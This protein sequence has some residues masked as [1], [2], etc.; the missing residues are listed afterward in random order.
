MKINDWARNGQKSGW[1]K[2]SFWWN[3]CTYIGFIFNSNF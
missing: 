2:V 1:C 3:G